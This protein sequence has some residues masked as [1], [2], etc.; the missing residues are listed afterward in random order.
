MVRKRK[1]ELN[2]KLI[3]LEEGNF[4][5]ILSGTINNIHECHWIIDTGASKSVFDVTQIDM[6]KP[7]DNPEQEI[8]SAGIGEGHIETSMGLLERLSFGEVTETDF[9][10]ALINFTHI[11]QLYSQFTDSDVH[12]LLGS[13]F[14]LAHQAV[15]DYRK[16]TLTLKA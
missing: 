3:E 14:L 12:G 9:Y 5:I 11:N 7:I 13:D 1:H 15:I 2:L 8:R 10:V 6:Y 4:H 16:L